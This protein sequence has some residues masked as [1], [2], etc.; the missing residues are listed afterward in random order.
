MVHTG[1]LTSVTWI[2]LWAIAITPRA[3]SREDVQ[4]RRLPSHDRTEDRDPEN[5][6]PV[7][8]CPRIALET[9]RDWPKS[10]VI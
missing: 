3:H 10:C 1:R 6:G 2:F 7:K 8:W 9:A 5:G 4:F